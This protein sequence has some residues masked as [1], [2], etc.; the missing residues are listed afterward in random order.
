ML[1]LAALLGTVLGTVL[2]VGL[3]VAAATP[4]EAAGYRYWSFWQSDGRAWSYATEGPATARPADG[5][6]NGF[7]FA[8]SENSAD[9]TRPRQAPDFAA[10]CGTTAAE[11]DRKRVAVVIDPGTPQDAPS[12]ERPPAP[13]A[14]CARVGTDATAAEA[15]AAVAKPLRYNQQALLCAIAGYPGA[16][17][18]EQVPASGDRPRT[19]AGAAPEGDTRAQESSAEESG[20]P[21][22]GA[23]AGVGAVVVLGAAAFWQS[24]RRSR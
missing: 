14:A 19:T 10:V 13:R 6:V 15:L 23:L 20:G 17:C 5:S 18:G 21:S 8:V 9:A 16:G 2:A 11:P 3:G 7:R 12:G 24:R 22:V 1:A 4:A